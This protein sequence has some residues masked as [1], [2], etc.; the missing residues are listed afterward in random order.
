VENTIMVP[1]KLKI[2]SPHDLAIRFVNTHPKELKARVQ[3][4]ICTPMFIAVV[5]TMAGG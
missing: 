3:I 2:G 4:H 1:Q 5:F